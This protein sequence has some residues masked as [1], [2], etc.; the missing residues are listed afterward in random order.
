MTRGPSSRFHFLCTSL[1]DLRTEKMLV[2]LLRVA[3]KVNLGVAFLQPVVSQA[4]PR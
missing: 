3:D 2:F 4:E 1:S